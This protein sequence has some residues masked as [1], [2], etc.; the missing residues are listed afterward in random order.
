MSELLNKIASLPV[1]KE[2]WQRVFDNQGCGGSDGI[3]LNRFAWSLEDNLVDLSRSLSREEY[4]P[5]PLLRF[6][7]PK[8]SGRGE[9]FLSVPTVRDR[10]A[11]AAAFVTTR[12]IFEAEFESV[13]HAYREGRG[14]QTA[15]AEIKKWREKGYMF[16]VDAD[17]DAYFD[18]VP[19]DLLIQRLQKLIADPSVIRLFQKWIQVEVYDGQRIWMLEKGIPQGSVVSPVLANLF[20][21][22]LD[23]ILLS[24][25][26]KLVRFADDFLVLSK[27][28]HEAEENIELTD[29]I[30]DD[31]KLDLNP[32]K[33]KIVS[34]E[35]GFK[36]LG[37]VFL[38]E[39]IY[40]PMPEKKISDGA[41]IKFPPPLSLRRYLELRNRLVNE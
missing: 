3:T 33:T 32:L 35:R 39:G 8:K 25:G 41:K 13:S 2:G 12:E 14:V 22:Q 7:I 4:Q 19:H 1:L 30:L 37:A 29:M 18:S 34:F 16:A 31:L 28:E 23:E 36:F 20:L 9:R 24:F 10:V 27:T 40:L 11:Q 5:Y 6:A 17:I 26:K 15:I 21:D 38:K